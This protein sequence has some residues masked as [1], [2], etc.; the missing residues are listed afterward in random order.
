MKAAGSLSESNIEE[1]S[2]I[3]LRWPHIGA[4]KMVRLTAGQSAINRLAMTLSVVLT[5]KIV[6][7]HL[8]LKLR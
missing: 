2:E 1:V 7:P 5:T 3:V 6:P 4:R 8:A